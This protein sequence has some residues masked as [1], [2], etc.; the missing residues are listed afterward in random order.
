ML[1]LLAD[2]LHEQTPDKVPEEEWPELFKELRAQMV[3]ALPGESIAA[4]GLSGKDTD[5]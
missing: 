1:R 3:Y 5:A 4:L 2:I